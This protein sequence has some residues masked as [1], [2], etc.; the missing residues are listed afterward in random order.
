M[1]ISFVSQAGFTL[2]EL[3]IVIA[4][5]GILAAI[6]LPA[7]Q[8]YLGRAQVMEGFKLTEGLR[9]E[10]S[11]WLANY[12]VFPNAEAV[13]INGTIGSQANALQGKYTQG[14][15]IKVTADTGAITINFDK[16]AIA[17]KNIILTPY[18]NQQS[19][20]QV[21]QWQCS[22]TVGNERLPTSCQ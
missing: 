15:G 17:G 12:K 10:I 9:S 14:N 13:A 6:A 4:I 8:N 3:I 7:Y 1:K 16:G 20:E 19:N 5:V 11:I 22:G 18:V 21:I 2:V